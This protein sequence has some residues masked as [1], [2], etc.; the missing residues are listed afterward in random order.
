MTILSEDYFRL[1]LAQNSSKVDNYI[2][3]N[4]HVRTITSIEEYLSYFKS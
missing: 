3:H 2:I 4:E 1:G